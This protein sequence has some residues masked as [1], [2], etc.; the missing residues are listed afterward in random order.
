MGKQAK[1][2][3]TPA[4]WLT[5]LALRTV[6][7]LAL[8]LPY[9]VRVR[10]FGWATRNLIAPLAGYQRRAEANLA[11]VYPDMPPAQ[12]RRIARAVAD[13]AGRTLI[14]NYSTRD[15][16]ER[17]AGITPTG[18]G[19]A[20]LQAARDAG[21][22]VI[23]VTGHFGNYEAARAALVSR[24]YDIGGL[25]RPMANPFFNAH[26]VRTMQAYGGPIFAQGR[27]GTTGFVR[28]L[29]SGGILVLLTDQHNRRGT[30]LQFMGHPAR[31]ALSAAELALRYGADLIPFY[32][33]RQPDGLSF[34]VTLEAPV[35][36]STPTQMM[37]TL[38]DSL[39]ARV[40]EHPE[41]WFWVHRR[42]KQR[43]RRA[44]S[45]VGAS[46]KAP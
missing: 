32:A 41:Q 45:G 16:L 37:Q 9:A 38:N 30:D 42:W 33:T 24:G 20:A 31:T 22:P 46:P 39:E 7:A 14:E 8:V 44:R 6:I 27:R 23:L 26:Y 28:H 13:N 29:R 1:R 4:N 19:M 35:P 25:Y 15:F 36:H 40:R 18:P 5:D 21:R 43:V 2:G 10:F 34:A 3:H 12:R 17:A 11:L